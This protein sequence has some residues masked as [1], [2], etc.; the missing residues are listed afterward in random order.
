MSLKS[1]IVAIVPCSH[2]LQKK[3]ENVASQA[4]LFINLCSWRK[5]RSLRGKSASIKESMFDDWNSVEAESTYV[6][7]ETS[8]DLLDLK[9]RSKK[10]D[11]GALSNSKMEFYPRQWRGPF[12]GVR[13]RIH[14]YLLTKD[15]FPKKEELKNIA[16]GYLELETQGLTGL[17][18]GEP[19]S[20]FDFVLIICMLLS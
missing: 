4:V 13:G 10:G 3:L 18:K 8:I 14:L 17:P 6:G 2:H 16:E 1:I 20:F 12:K 19:H 15:P 11:K 7:S 5:T 9:M